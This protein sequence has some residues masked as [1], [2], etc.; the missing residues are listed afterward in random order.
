MLAAHPGT[1]IAISAETMQCF[2]EPAL[3]SFSKTSGL[4]A[5][6][7][8]HVS[9]ILGLPTAKGHSTFTFPVFACD[10][11]SEPIPLLPSLTHSPKVKRNK[12]VKISTQTRDQYL[13]SWKH[14]CS[15]YFPFGILPPC[16]GSVPYIH[17]T[18]KAHPSGPVK[19]KVSVF[20][21]E[22]RNCSRF[23]VTL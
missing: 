10:M 5:A 1:F 20:T 15:D 23:L 4:C 3:R 8:A 6:L 13:T 2:Q 21:E 14:L 18:K 11:P 16:T 22:C 12:H 9:P 7:R 19:A 17:T